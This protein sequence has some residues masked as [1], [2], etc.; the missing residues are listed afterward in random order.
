MEELT[1]KQK[2]ILCFIIEYVKSHSYPPTIREIAEH[3]SISTK[4]AFDH[5]SALKRKKK[6][7]MRDSGSRTLEV[8]AGVDPEGFIDIPLLGKVA[9]G[10]HILFEEE[11]NNNSYIRMHN[12]MLKKNKCYFALNVCGDSMTG[13]GIMDGDT[14]IIEKRE[15]AKNGDIVVVDI[16]DGERM[17]KRFNRQGHRIKLA[18]ENPKYSPIYSTDVHIL[19][20]LAGVYRI[21]I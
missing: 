5:V 14:V 9:A 11:E 8:I 10:K 16:D 18:P 12:S 19:G 13:I 3:F 4:G 15:T 17:L 6:I 1:E 21:Y 7:K 20:K 2:G